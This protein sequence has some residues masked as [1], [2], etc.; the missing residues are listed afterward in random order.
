MVEARSRRC[1]DL[2][3]VQALVSSQAFTVLSPKPKDVKRP[4]EESKCKQNFI[5]VWIVKEIFLLDEEGRKVSLEH[6]GHIKYMIWNASDYNTKSCA[7]GDL[8][9]ALVLS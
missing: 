8:L 2:D 4:D 3:I 7:W 6:E 1:S 5:E 9:S